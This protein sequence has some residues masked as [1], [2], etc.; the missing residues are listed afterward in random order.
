[1]SERNREASMNEAEFRH[2][3]TRV[4]EC[5][6]VLGPYFFREERERIE[7]LDKLLSLLGV[8]VRHKDQDKYHDVLNIRIPDTL[9]SAPYEQ[10]EMLARGIG[11]HV[12]H[13][14]LRLVRRK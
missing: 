9:C 14:L 8:A 12:T 2:S 11:D 3:I 13:F 1:M 10:A 6:K 5:L 7:E 4:E